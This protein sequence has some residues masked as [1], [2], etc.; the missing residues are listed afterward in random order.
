MIQ[1]NN[2][3]ALLNIVRTIG[4]EF[5]KDFKKHKIPTEP[6]EFQKMFDTIDK[7]CLTY[8]KDN[9]SKLYP[10]IPW[11]DD[12]LNIEIQKQD[13]NLASYW[14]CDSMDGAVQ[15][16]QH[17]LGWTINLVLMKN[18]QPDL[19]IIYDPLQNEMFW[20]EN[21][22]GAFLNNIELKI[23]P[24]NNMEVMLACFNHSPL[25]KS[26][27]GLNKKTSNLVE[28]LLNEFGAVRNYGPTG[29]Q[30][31]NVGAGRIDIFCQEGLDTYNWLAG[32]LIAKE[33]GAT[34][35]NKNGNSWQWGDDTL[36][37]SSSNILSKF[38]KTI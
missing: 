27:L 34:I 1:T 9:I 29:L 32:I 15:Y 17:L 12:E 7:K 19:A 21:A 24:K 33:A 25:H 38:I 28:K 2:I 23:A 14:I 26:V 37:V 22:K 36:F 8:L 5:A 30:I 13:S 4:N 6:E 31:A 18:G 10:A 20:A 35:L 3:S 11:A 16:M